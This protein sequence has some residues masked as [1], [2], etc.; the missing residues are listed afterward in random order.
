MTVHHVVVGVVAAASI[1]LPV[2][3]VIANAALGW[4]SAGFYLAFV[5]TVIAFVVVGWLISVR[6]PDNVIGP[7]LLAFGFVFAT[8]FPID[9]LV[10][11][12]SPTHLVQV[13]AAFS[14]ASDAPGFIIVAM[15]LILFP[16]GRLPGPGWRWV[17]IVAGVGV[18]SAMIGF[19]LNAGPLAAFPGL[20]NPLGIPGFPGAVIGEIGYFC[21]IALLVGSVAA[22]ITRWRRGTAMERAQVKW[23]AAAAVV[24]AMMEAI[25]LATFDTSDPFGS[26]V[27]IVL[28][29]V[30]T[31]LVPIAIGIAILRYRLYEIDRLI[32]RTIGWA[33][34]T[35]VLLAVFVALVVGLQTALSGLT[36][37]DTVAVAASTL[38]AFALFQPVRRRVQ[39]AVDRRF[40]RARYDAEHTAAAF[41]E[42]L[43]IE[44]DLVDVQSDVAATVQAALRPATIGVWL[45]P[46]EPER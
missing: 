36:Q 30:A 44:V 37:G 14:S 17:P 33:V 21:L 40:D 43:R 15:I 7:L 38:V 26:P 25:N 12:G 39:H 27:A 6:R 9:L 31:A 5:P 41:A 42:R 45:R 35:G 20:E 1:A 28:A 16:D 29:T 8:Y 2:A 22:L 11:P 24:L 46:P 32:S 13:A 3:V 4:P 23:V 18:V 10:R 19:S 34:V